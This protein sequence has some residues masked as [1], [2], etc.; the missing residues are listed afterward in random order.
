MKHI[1]LALTTTLCVTS[2]YLHAAEPIVDTIAAAASA[3]A[4]TVINPATPVDPFVKFMAY[5]TAAVFLAR[6]VVKLTP[7][8]KDDTFLDNLITGLKHIGLTIKDK[9]FLW[10]AALCMLSLSSCSNGMFLGLNRGQWGALGKDVGKTAG[11]AALSG[12]FAKNP[13]DLTSGK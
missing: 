9:P 3:P 5:V 12:Y 2:C 1:L 4:A 10:L 6:I 7:T 13:I 11:A 8:P